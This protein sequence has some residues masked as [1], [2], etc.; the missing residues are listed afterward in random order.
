MTID[1]DIARLKQQEEQLRFK[2]FSE[3]PKASCL[4]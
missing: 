1:N 3:S 4:W 2:S